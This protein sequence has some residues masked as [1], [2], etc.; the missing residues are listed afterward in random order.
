MSV[1]EVDLKVGGSFRVPQLCSSTGSRLTVQIPLPECRI[2]IILQ[3]G[4]PRHIE[5][6]G[7]ALQFT[8]ELT[9]VESTFDKRAESTAFDY[10]MNFS[11]TA[12]MTDV[13]LI[14]FS[15]AFGGDQTVSNV[16]EALLKALNDAFKDK[17]YRLFSV[18]LK[19]VDEKYP[20]LVPSRIKYAFIQNAKS[21]D[22]NVVGVLVQT[23]GT[24]SDIIQLD[25]RTIPAECNGSAVLSNRVA[26]EGIMR[27]MVISV[28]GVEASN[29]KMEKKV[30][31]PIVLYAGKPF[32][33][34]EEV[35]GYRPE[36]SK[37]RVWLS[38]DRLN[39]EMDA[40]AE[41]SPG[42]SV[43]YSVKATSKHTIKTVKKNG[44]KYQEIEF[45]K[46]KYEENRSA[47]AEWW[48]WL[49]SSLFSWVPAMIIGITLAVA[50]GKAPELGQTVFG[51]ALATVKW[52]HM[53]LAEIKYVNTD[54]HIQIGGKV[55]LG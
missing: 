43:K 51:K 28:T 47:V 4:V 14:G 7:G 17:K 37:L 46:D 27:D 13:E 49:L 30:N 20:Y 33:Y 44:Q 26:M 15:E 31:S 36:I 24:G 32:V 12:L 11:D 6:K 41:F 38:D 35:D 19:G 9:A 45:E 22:D 18:D 50:K 2:D 1:V 53:D 16:E 23:D 42:M 3:A 8:T 39:L 34:K 55:K 40:A 48:V 25:S 54:G 21:P 29:L 5:V 10:Y 52:N